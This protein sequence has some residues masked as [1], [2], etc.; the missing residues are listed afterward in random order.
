M[1]L[2][3]NPKPKSVKQDHCP[4]EDLYIYYLR[5]RLKPEKDIFKDNFI[6][7]WEEEN[8]SFLFFSSPAQSDVA[9]LLATQPQLTYL[10]SYRMSYDQWQSEKFTAFQHGKFW[11][12]PAW[13]SWPDD[14]IPSWA[15]AGAK[16]EPTGQSRS[17]PTRT[18]TYD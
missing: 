8:F 15:L 18:G 9:K 4:Y 16:P 5:G 1:T 6:G 2:P 10:D 14:T 13:E 3:R 7:N 11:I 17:A 12:I